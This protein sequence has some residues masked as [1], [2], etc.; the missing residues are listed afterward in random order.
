MAKVG[1]SKQ[2]EVEKTCCVWFLF[3]YTSYMREVAEDDGGA[4]RV[5]RRSLA[6]AG[7]QSAGLFV[8]RCAEEY[9]RTVLRTS[10]LSNRGGTGWS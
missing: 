2:D 4:A 8:T 5:V 6:G 7:P 1:I 3:L 10:F 9:E